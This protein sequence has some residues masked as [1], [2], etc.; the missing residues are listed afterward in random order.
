MA[1]AG[2]DQTALIAQTVTL[3]GSKSSDVDGNPLTF[4]WSFVSRPGGSTAT[5]S[6]PTAVQPTFIV[7][8]EGTYVVQLVVND[9]LVN[10][11]PDT[12]SISS[13]NTKPVADAGPDQTALIAQTVTLDGSKSSDVDGNPLTF[14]WS[15]VS[16]P[17]GSTATLSDPTAVK[18][19]F[20]V[21]AEGT[22]VVQLVVN[23]G[24]VNSAP[25]TVS[26]SSVNTK[27]VADAGPD[28]TAL[29]AQTVTL[30]G[31]KSSDV[32]GNPL[33]FF[34]SFV[35][36]PGGSTATLSDPTAVKPTFVV[37]AEGTY[38]VQLVVND[39]FEDS[40]P[41]TVSI[42]SVNTKPVADAGPDQT[43][44]IAQTVTLDGSKS[45][46]VDGNPLTFFWSFASRPG[47]STATLSDP[48]A[49]KPTFIVDAEGTYVVQL[50]VN[51]GLADSDPD[52]VSISS[53]N[54]KPVADAGPDQTAFVTQ[55]VTLDGSKSSD[56]D[57]DPLTFFWSFASRPAGSTATLSDP[58][59]VK[60][61]FTVD[62]AGTYVVQLMVND[63]L[64]DSAPDTVS[65]STLNSKPVADGVP[66]R[67]SIPAIRFSLTVANPPMLTA[68]RLLTTGPSLRCQRLA[69]R[70]SRTQ[71]RPS[72][73]S[74]RI[75]LAPMWHN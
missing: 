59:A 38:V 35:S 15:F 39:G 55:T 6:D 73:P 71:P 13:V 45:S 43:A 17:G 53:V 7:D 30:D 32:D 41:D 23:D 51:D 27:P 31:S 4:F 22:Y 60:P 2:P 68:I 50:V 49:V 56:V 65:I 52:T 9:G 12:V 25:D 63:G 66:T 48:T 67:A 36:R 29:I 40:A 46:D 16:R 11:A 34:W 54:T 44:L 26:I 5:L 21:D 72:Q 62:V 47:G 58:T 18:P 42:S 61:A 24:L 74:F 3:D 10:S 1:D 70:H 33:T 37:D 14:F 75:W 8:A 20:I 64:A 57:G 69:P 28:Q 19:T